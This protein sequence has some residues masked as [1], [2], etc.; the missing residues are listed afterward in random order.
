[1]RFNPWIARARLSGTSKHGFFKLRVISDH[2][3]AL[4]KRSSQL[5]GVTGGRIG[6]ALDNDWVLPDP[7]RYVSSHHARISFRTGNWILEDTSTNGIFING[8][9]ARLGGR[10]IR[11]QGRQPAARA[12]TKVWSASMSA[13][14]SA[15]DA[16]GQLPAPARVRQG[17][18][19]GAA[20]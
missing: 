1:M 8:A 5:F 3:K 6:R 11:A 12:F 4:G 17:K 19:A 10:P 2:Y 9:D 15:P 16:G 18:I 7:D 13:T 14:T 20:R